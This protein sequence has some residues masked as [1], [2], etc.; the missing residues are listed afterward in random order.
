M[1]L[2]KAVKRKMIHQRKIKCVGYLRSDGLWEIEGHLEDLKSY[3]FISKHR[4]KVSKGTPVHD[5]WIRITLNDSFKI[6]NVETSTNFS[7]YPNCSSIAP[8]YQKLK[9]LK[10]GV[11]WRKNII[12]SIGGVK[13]CTHLTELLAP[14]AT[15][16]FQTI[17]SY[18]LNKSKNK[19]PS[20]N[21]INSCH[22]YSEE[23][24]LVK[25]IFN[26]NH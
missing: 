23:G 11:G 17:Y 5:M 21:L 20:K 10:I 7:P 12:L 26:K 1:K 22:I 15:T 25:E 6:I 24:E 9:G 4:G 19:E 13:G 14:I 3:S 18:N 2:K 8:N 16:A